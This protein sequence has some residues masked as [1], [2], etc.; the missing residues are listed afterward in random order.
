MFHPLQWGESDSWALGPLREHALSRRP[1]A[2][3]LNKSVSDEQES[4]EKG[5]QERGGYGVL[6][7]GVCVQRKADLREDVS[8]EKSWRSKRALPVDR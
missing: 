4:D 7:R 6:R 1:H 3:G 2:C 5:P 8:L